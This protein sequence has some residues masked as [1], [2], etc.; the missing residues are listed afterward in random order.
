V[1]RSREAPPVG[2]IHRWTKAEDNLVVEKNEQL[3]ISP[4]N[5]ISVNAVDE[6]Q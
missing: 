2:R 5:Q 1:Q 3:G 4:K 6:P